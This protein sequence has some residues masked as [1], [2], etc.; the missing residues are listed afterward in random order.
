LRIN[1][2]LID[3]EADHYIWAEQFD[4]TA[5]NIFKLQDKITAK[6]ITALALELSPSEKK[7]ILYKETENYGAY[8]AYLKG[9]AHMRKFTPED[10]VKAIALF[11]KAI[12]LDPNYSKPYAAMAFA[13]WNTFSGGGVF[14][15]KLNI[16]FPLSRILARDYLRTAMKK[17]TTYSYILLALM[18]LWRR[19]YRES[20]EYA[21]KAVLISPNNAD[22][23]TFLGYILT[24][25]GNPEKGIAYHKKAIMLD[26]L[27][28]TTMG[29]GV[30]YFTMEEYQEAVK[31]GNIFSINV[32]PNYEGRIRA[33]DEK[34]LTEV[35]RMIKEYEG[36]NP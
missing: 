26:P 13:Y 14:Y 30:A 17:P 8:D 21:E 2:Q 16:D 7:T 11:K 1:A 9:M 19:H 23:L 20:I 34:T 18:E 4:G 35:G 25:N 22:A 32:G 31:Y 28:G 10:Y 29:I 12:K 33:I 36:I 5:K 3:A 24:A 15:E 27:H 6:I